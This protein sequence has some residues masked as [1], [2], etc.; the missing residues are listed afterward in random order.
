MNKD[1][2]IKEIIYNRFRWHDVHG[3]N[4]KIEIDSIEDVHGTLLIHYHYRDL[5]MPEK[6]SYR[7]TSISKTELRN[8][9]LNELDIK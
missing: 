5:D 8:F 6:S 3:I 7:Y 4:V 2:E 9:I 1:K